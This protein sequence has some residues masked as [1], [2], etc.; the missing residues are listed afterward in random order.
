MSPKK[1][2][3]VGAFALAIGAQQALAQKKPEKP[4]KGDVTALG[5]AVA[6]KALETQRGGQA[7]VINTADLDA[8]MQNNRAIGNTTGNNYLSDSAFSHSSGLPV[9]IQNS[10]N[11][12][13]LQNSFILNLQ[14]K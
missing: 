14:M 2:V 3:L 12:V 7:V 1:I 11:N 5:V 9:A 6:P 10:G 13:I 8:N 4:S